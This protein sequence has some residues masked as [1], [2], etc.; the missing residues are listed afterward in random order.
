MQNLISLVY[1]HIGKTLPV[2]IYDSIYQT[3]LVSSNTKIYIILDDTLISEVKNTVSKFNTDLY[4]KNQS[5]KSIHVEC[6]PISILKLPDEYITFVESLPEM[7]RN[8]RDSFWISTTARFFYIQSFMKLF[9]LTNVFHMEND[10]MLYDN[11][12][13]NVLDKSKL[14]M[15][16]DADNPPRVIPSIM[17][18]PNSLV[19][20][21][22]TSF[23]LKSLKESGMLLNDMQ[24]LGAYS[25]DDVEYFSFDFNSESDKIMDGAAIGQFLGGIDPRNI[26]DFANKSIVEQKVLTIDNPTRGFVNETCTFKVNSIEI[27][28]K[29][30]HLNN[31]IIPI[32][33]IYGKKEQDNTINLKQIVNL[34][35]H[36]KQ[37]YQYSSVN[38]LK[39][40]DI[41]SGD[42]IVSLCDFVLCTND[43]FNYHKNLGNFIDV[44]RVIIVKNFP[45]INTDALNEYFRELNKNTIKL[46]IYTHI[47]DEFV[48]Y[49]LPK[50]DTNLSYILY[51]HNSDHG[52]ED[53]S[54]FNALSEAKHIKKVYSQNINRYSPKKYKLLPIGLANSMF[55]HGDL[56][57]LYETISKTYYVK[58]TNGIYININ[59]NT[60]PYRHTVLNE[61]KR[62]EGEFNIV[63]ASKPYKEYLDELSTHRFCLCVR[64]NG[65]ACHREWESLYLG[66]IPVIINNKYTNLDAYVKYLKELNLPFFEIKEENFDRYNDDFF[67]EELYKKII[68]MC[69]NSIYNSESLKLNF[70]NE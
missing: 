12:Y 70:Y 42:R 30:L 23:I 29:E 24:L 34:H 1:I 7:T 15:V 66:V 54:H 6:I 11:L 61:L 53:K 58:K 50:L 4:I 47:L 33:L 10:I 27:F 19:L 37:L 17:Y 49:I 63:S 65:M 67:N 68:Y 3:L 40:K 22:L 60:Y 45:T 69:G 56:I 36:S 14:Y 48:K 31:T 38:N 20:S 9:Q 16:K 46:F 51:L 26:S 21:K 41:I 5:D 32:E 52:L 2:C 62:R 25:S 44:N 64:G 57:S 39:F 55:K 43:I 18:I 8:F 28:R 13:D 35:I 59:P